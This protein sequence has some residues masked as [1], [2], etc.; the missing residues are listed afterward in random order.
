MQEDTSSEGSC[1][2]SPRE[3]PSQTDSYQTTQRETGRKRQAGSVS[4]DEGWSTD[5]FNTYIWKRIKFIL[6]S[7][8]RRNIKRN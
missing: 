5:L 6:K 7:A 2:R 8:R 3:F 1:G 4:R